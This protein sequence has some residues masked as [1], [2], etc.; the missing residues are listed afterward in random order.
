MDQQG[1]AGG[2]TQFVVVGIKAVLGEQIFVQQPEG[3]GGL[4]L[5]VIASALELLAVDVGPAID[6]ALRQ[7]AILR[8]AS[9][10]HKA[11]PRCPRQKGVAT[12]DRRVTKLNWLTLPS[13]L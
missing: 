1:V 7:M 5:I 11:G 9:L 13:E 2:V 4:E 3:I 12:A 6:D 8:D 10:P